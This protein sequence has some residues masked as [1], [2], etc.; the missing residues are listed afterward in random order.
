MIDIYQEDLMRVFLDEAREILD[1]MEQAALQ[2]ETAGDDRDVVRNLFRRAHTLKGNAACVGLDR[3]SALAHGVEDAFEA[4]L[5]GRATPGSTLVTALLAV[6]DV[7]RD[8]MAGVAA[9]HGDGLDESAIATLISGLSATG[10]DATSM[11]G[12][13]AAATSAGTPPMGHDNRRDESGHDAKTLRI[14]AQKLDRILTLTSEMAIARA[15]MQAL[16]DERA[17]H[18]NLVEVFE[19]TERLAHDLQEEVLDARM[20]PIGP[21]FRQYSRTV[22]DT[23]LA[24]GKKVSLL[25]EGDDVELDMAVV[26]QL[27]DP[28]AQMLRNAIDHGIESPER[29]IAANKPPEGLI[30]FA[31][32]R[33]AASFLLSI[34]DDGAGLDREAILET[35]RHR[36]LR[37]DGEL[38]DRDVYRLIFEPGFSTAQEVSELS[39][40]G[41]GMDIVWRRVEALRGSIRVESVA[42]RGTTFTIRL[43]LTL[44]IIPGFA[45]GIGDETYVLPREAMVACREVPSDAGAT[46]FIEFQGSAVPIVD[47]HALFGVPAEGSRPRQAV[48]VRDGA[49]LAALT[50]DRLLG[51]RQVVVKP[52][53]R[54]FRH[55]PGVAGSAILENGRIALVLE[56]SAILEK[57]AAGATLATMSDAYHGGAAIRPLQTVRGS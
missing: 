34:T 43:P 41:F 51:E 54:L 44:A 2:L 53:G 31:A 9:G 55:V 25:I 14:D 36:G 5:D 47:L 35:A 22:R 32:R 8:A 10:C 19:E 12:D 42:G 50:A 15:R 38:A 13:P 4:L 29:R 49:W 3:V 40:R 46:P 6:V 52:L 18:E 57:C 16:L 21:T 28:V 17:P 48:I 20:I 23:A 1:E 33:D 37:V 27:R 30:R 7:F 56:I 45:I 24:H 11:R 26:E 39:G